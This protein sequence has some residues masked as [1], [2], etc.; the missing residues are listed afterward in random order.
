MSKQ[1][2]R[3]KDCPGEKAKA[4]D[5]SAAIGQWVNKSEIGPISEISFRL[6]KNGSIVQKGKGAEMIFSV[7]QLIAYISKYFT[8]K[9]GDVI[10]TGTPEGVGPVF[11]DDRLKAF[12]G[13]QCL[14]EILVK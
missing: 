3:K 10:F 11:A 14:L 2:S 6:E 12:I 13:D 7:D 1:N 4:F 9:K 8:L 5:G